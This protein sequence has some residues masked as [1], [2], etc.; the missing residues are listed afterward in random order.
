MTRALVTHPCVDRP[1][2]RLRIAVQ[3][4]LVR[5]LNRATCRAYDHLVDLENR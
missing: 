3:R 5:A 1:M 4:H 2:T